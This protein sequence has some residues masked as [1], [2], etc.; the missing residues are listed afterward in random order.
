[1]TIEMYYGSIGRDDDGHEFFL[2]DK[3]NLPV[4]IKPGKRVKKTY[5]VGNTKLVIEGHCDKNNLGGTVN[6]TCEQIDSQEWDP[7]HPGWIKR[8]GSQWVISR[9]VGMGQEISA[10]LEN[11]SANIGYKLKH[12]SDIK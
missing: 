12:R 7:E 6:G 1:M 11:S 9:T 8:N 10:H 3:V 4:L 2:N 5:K